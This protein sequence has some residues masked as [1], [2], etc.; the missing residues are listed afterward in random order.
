MKQFTN[1]MNYNLDLEQ[2]IESFT[3]LGAKST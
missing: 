2:I 1:N 3:N